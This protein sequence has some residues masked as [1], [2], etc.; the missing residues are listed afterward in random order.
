[1][2]KFLLKCISKRNIFVGILL[3]PTYLLN[4]CVKKGQHLHINENINVTVNI[5]L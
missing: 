4:Y 3:N 2:L 1:M 5:D